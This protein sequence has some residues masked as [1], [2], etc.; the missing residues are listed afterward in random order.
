VKKLCTYHEYRFSLG[1]AA[2]AGVLTGLAD[3]TI[4]DW[5]VKAFVWSAILM[6]YS[7]I[8]AYEF[9]VM[10]TPP[11]PLLQA[12]LFILITPLGLLS[13]HHFTWYLLIIM[14][15]KPIEFRL[16]LAPNIYVNI[17]KYNVLMITSLLIYMTYLIMTNLISC[18]KRYER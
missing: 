17:D 7:L 9:I 10:P 18:E 3:A 11:R 15:G 12:L 14:L 4:E 16:W 1:L 8:V 13:A 6:L 5:S 2:I